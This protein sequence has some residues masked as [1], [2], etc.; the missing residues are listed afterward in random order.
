MRYIE[1]DGVRHE[2]R[3]IRELRRRQILE[4]R[5]IS[6]LTLFE[7]KD[8]SRPPSQCTASGRFEEPLLFDK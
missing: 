2:W 6:Q 1:I 5:R 8:D 3:K 7:L 4:A